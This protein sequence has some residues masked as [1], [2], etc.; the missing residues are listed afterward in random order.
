MTTTF[1]IFDKY[2]SYKMCNNSV[3]IYFRYKMYYYYYFYFWWEKNKMS[4][5]N[6]EVKKIGFYD[7]YFYTF[8]YVYDFEFIL[9][10]LEN[11]YNL[12]YTR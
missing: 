9:K 7:F 11:K 3:Y 5:V 10:K 1:L 8:I 2:V 12:Y 4:K 6:S